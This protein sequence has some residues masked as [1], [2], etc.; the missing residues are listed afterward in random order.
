MATE[1]ETKN[2]ELKHLGF[3]RIAAIRALVCVSNLYNYGK[4][5]SGPL[6][7]TVSTVEG[8][9]TAVV[10]PVYEKFKTVPDHLLVFLDH[11][12][13]EHKFDKHAPCRTSFRL[14]ERVRT[15]AEA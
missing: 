5:N 13:D 10:S 8:T 3:V 2:Q 15:D 4:R 6:K 1:T 9:V 7:S 11:K 12:V 14:C